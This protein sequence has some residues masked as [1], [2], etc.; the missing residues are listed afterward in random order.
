MTRE[1]Q[2]GDWFI[3]LVECA[4]QSLYT[5]IAR[6]VTRRVAEHNEGRG[7]AKYTRARRPVTLVYV[8]TAASRADA[9][10]REAAIKKLS[11]K[12][13]LRLLAADQ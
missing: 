2:T 9:L 11:R 7:A 5:G 4:D 10:R 1:T 12:E 3:Y 6:D 13:K 8:E